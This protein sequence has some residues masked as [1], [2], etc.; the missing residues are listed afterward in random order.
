MS[1]NSPDAASL[2]RFVATAPLPQRVAMRALLA[3]ARRP[4]GAR[5]LSVLSPL[6]QLPSGLLAMVR[7]DQPSVSRPLGWDAEAVVA[8]GRALRRREGRP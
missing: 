5:L 7:Y 2:E 1:A 6:D 8:R 4:R 3:L